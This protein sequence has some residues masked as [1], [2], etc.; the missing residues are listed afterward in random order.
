MVEELGGH[1]VHLSPQMYQ[2]YKWNSSHR[3]PAE[4]KQGTLDT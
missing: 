3:A 1:G 4:Y 2:E